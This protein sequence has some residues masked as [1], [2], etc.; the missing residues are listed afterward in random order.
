M[1]RASYFPL[2]V[3]RKKILSTKP[4]FLSQSAMLTNHSLD[5]NSENGIPDFDPNGEMDLFSV[6]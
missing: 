6:F 4:L 5:L 3:E 1:E 2:P